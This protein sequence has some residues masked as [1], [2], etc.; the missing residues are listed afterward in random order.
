MADVFYNFQNIFNFLGLLFRTEIPGRGIWPGIITCADIENPNIGIFFLQCTVCG[1][2]T[3]IIR[4]LIRTQCPFILDPL[5]KW[6]YNVDGLLKNQYFRI[7][8]IPVKVGI[9]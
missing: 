5:L 4:D 1:T 7:T 8:V 2:D 3:R 9:Q 6:Q